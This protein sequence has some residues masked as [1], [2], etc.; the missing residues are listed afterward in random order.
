MSGPRIGIVGA[1]GVGVAA[2][3]AIVM[4]GLAGRVTIYSRTADTAR[5]LALDFLHAQPLL[6]HIEI[7]GLGSDSIEEEDVLVITAGHHTTPGEN[8]MDTLRG[9]LEVMEEVATAV[10]AGELPRVALVVTNPLDVMT[11]YL[12]RR[13]A[14]RGVAVMGSGTALDTLRLTQR[15]ATDCQV[16]PRSVHS[17]V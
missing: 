9:N 5:G 12:S 3:S 1:G 14:G 17:W 4:R 8:R 13:W 2:A 16:H 15:I 6:P 10:E 7:R 11:E